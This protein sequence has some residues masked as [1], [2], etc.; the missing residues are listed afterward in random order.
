MPGGRRQ[1]ASITL[2]DTLLL[3]PAGARSLAAIGAAMGE[4]KLS[5][6]DVLDERGTI[7]PGIERMDLVLEQHRD[8]FGEYAVQD[9]RIAALWLIE[10]ARVG[11]VLG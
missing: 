11:R 8:V 4:P 6:P 3:T 1:K 5:V 9:A 7:L 10:A 2:Y